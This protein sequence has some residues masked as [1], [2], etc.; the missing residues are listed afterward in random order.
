MGK[1]SQRITASGCE[2][3]DNGRGSHKAHY[4]SVGPEEDR[5]VPASEVGENKSSTEE[6]CL[7]RPLG[8]QTNP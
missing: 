3:E 6:G 4:V 2:S 7:V 1:R 8:I 5:G